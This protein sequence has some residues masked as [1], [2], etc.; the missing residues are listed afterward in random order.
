MAAQ[1]S[2]RFDKA[3]LRSLFDRIY[4]I[5]LPD[6]TDRRREME[7]QLARIGL[8]GDPLVAYFPAVRPADKGEFGSLGERGCFLSHLGALKDAVAQGHRSILILEDDVDWT[9]AAL[10]RNARL[11]ALRDT[12]WGFLHGGRGHDR[13]APD[14]AI[15]LVRLEPER[16]LLLGHFIGLRGAVIG[17]MVDYLEAMLARPKGSPDGGPMHVDGAYSWFRRARPEVAAYV[18]S[19]SV[20]Q[21]RS[22]RS[23]ISVPTGWRATRAADWARRVLRPVRALLRGR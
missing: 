15:S 12:D 3:L 20:A 8:A 4:V 9:P 16:E 13:A 21:Q 5:N 6:R 11:D 2:S 10:A 7:A 17:Q 14:G 1:T 18:C 22:S 23:D 19:P